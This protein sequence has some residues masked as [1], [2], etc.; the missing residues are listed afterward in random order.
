MDCG[1]PTGGI[2]INHS[3]YL[4]PPKVYRL[5]SFLI[6]ALIKNSTVLIEIPEIW[7]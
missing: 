7:A 3:Q 4:S 5:E 2:V 1:D 6:D